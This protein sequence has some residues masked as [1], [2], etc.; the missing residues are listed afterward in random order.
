VDE[1]GDANIH[2]AWYFH[3]PSDDKIYVETSKQAK[4]TY[5]LRFK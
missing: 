2:P 4:K 3:D 5:N 1:K